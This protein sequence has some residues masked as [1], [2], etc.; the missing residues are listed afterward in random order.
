MSV[1]LNTACC[2]MSLPPHSQLP[3]TGPA[4]LLPLPLQQDVILRGGKA[5]PL[6]ARVVEAGVP[7]AVVLPAVPGGQLQVHA[8][9]RGGGR[10]HAEGA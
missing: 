8:A 1:L 3:L 9:G 2:G 10:W 6:Y 4:V 7:R 5:L